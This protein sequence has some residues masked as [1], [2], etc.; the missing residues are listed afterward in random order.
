LLFFTFKLILIGNI[1]II[2]NLIFAILLTINIYKNQK[3]Y[4][5]ILSIYPLWVSIATTLNTAIWILN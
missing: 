3:Y 4:A 1:T 5:Y 2:L